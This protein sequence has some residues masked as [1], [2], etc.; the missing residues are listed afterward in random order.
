MIVPKAHIFG[1]EHVSPK[2]LKWVLGESPANKPVKKVKRR[3]LSRTVQAAC[4]DI[5]LN[6]LKC[7][8]INLKA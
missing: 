2:F 5:S 8:N 3:S 6:V 7:T 1:E 4:S